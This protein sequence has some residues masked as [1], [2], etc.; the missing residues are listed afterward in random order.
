MFH[1]TGVRQAH[2]TFNN[3]HR[4]MEYSHPASW[5]TAIL[6]NDVL[7]IKA[8]KKTP[9]WKQGKVAQIDNHNASRYGRLPDTDL[10]L[11]FK[12]DPVCVFG[13]MAIDAAFPPTPTDMA[14]PYKPEFVD[15]YIVRA[16][17]FGVEHTHEWEWE[18]EAADILEEYGASQEPWMSQTTH[19][20]DL[21]YMWFTREG[22]MCSWC[23]PEQLAA[24]VNGSENFKH[25]VLAAQLLLHECDHEIRDPDLMY[26]I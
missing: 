3:K 26:N 11:D 10:S 18:C 21:L 15:N 5:S 20:F 17:T 4:I 9:V 2:G 8:G 1:K 22:Y 6:R 12:E 14:T 23:F 19:P 16:T 25:R 7:D 24:A 13:R